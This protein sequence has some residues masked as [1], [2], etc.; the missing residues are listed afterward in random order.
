MLLNNFFSGNLE[1][2]DILPAF[3]W[4]KTETVLKSGHP[5]STPDSSRVQLMLHVAG[6][7]CQ[8]GMPKDE[9]DLQKTSHPKV[10]KRDLRN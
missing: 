9:E 1:R 10:P 3:F 6:N 4:W 5:V 8:K 2:R 7:V